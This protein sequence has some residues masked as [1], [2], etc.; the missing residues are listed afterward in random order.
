MKTSSGLTFYDWETLDLVRRIE[1]VPRCVFFFLFKFILPST[2]NHHNDFRFYR[3]IFWNET[4]N[5]VCLATDDCYFI[6]RVDTGAIQTAI[7]AKQGLGEDGLEDAFE[8]RLLSLSL[9]QK[10][11]IRNVS[12][13]IKKN[14][15][16]D[17]AQVLGEV[18]EQ[19]KTGIWVGDC[20]IYTN[21]VNRINYYVGGE[22]VTISHLDR[23]MYLLGY[24]AKDNR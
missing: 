8:V 7:D 22:I 15:L 9:Y 23:T 13:F 11:M 12:N 24:V 19:V 4:G 3:N 16:F 20:F 6:L 14:N 10:H 2:F 18:N 17:N 21:S 5:L 1:V